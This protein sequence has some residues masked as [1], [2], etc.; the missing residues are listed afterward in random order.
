MGSRGPAKKPVKIVRLQGNPGKRDHDRV[1]SP[2]VEA[3]PIK[4]DMEPP[5]TL[6]PEERDKWDRITYN[7]E[8]LGLLTVLDM[9]ALAR[10][11]KILALYDKIEDEFNPRREGSTVEFEETKY[12]Q[13]SVDAT[14]YKQWMQVN[15][16]LLRMEKEFG[17]TPSS[18]SSLIAPL[19]GEDK[20]DFQNFMNLRMKQAKGAA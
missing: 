5:I 6:F 15:R 9:D 11:C 18:R 13:K 4:S 19:E 3:E 17:F 1:N 7:L 12:G 8:Q 16:D 20:G 2:D 14:L 10:Y